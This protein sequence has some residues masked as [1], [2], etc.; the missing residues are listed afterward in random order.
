M[1][2]CEQLPS[3]FNP[4]LLSTVLK[5]SMY[6]I[7][8]KITFILKMILGM[9]Q[10]YDKDHR[11]YLNRASFQLNFINKMAFLSKCLTNVTNICSFLNGPFSA[12]F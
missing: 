7:I 10:H 8:I 2:K 9:I 11:D 6:I 5:N 4:S 12:S 3:I 1:K